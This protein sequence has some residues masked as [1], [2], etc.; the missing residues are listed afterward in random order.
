[1]TIE[2]KQDQASGTFG[3][4]TTFEKQKKSIRDMFLAFYNE[5]EFDYTTEYDRK[6]SN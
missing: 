2:L 1:M 6:E 3:I 4:E 5:R